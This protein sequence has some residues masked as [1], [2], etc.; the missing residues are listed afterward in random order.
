[1][2]DGYVALD[3][4]TATVKQIII[5]KPDG[6]NLTKGANFVTDGKDGKLYYLTVAGDFDQAGT[7]RTQ[8]KIVMP[9][10]SGYSSATTFEVLAN[11]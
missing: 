10:F 11:I 1:L 5:D 7:Y 3:I 2:R 4:S 6:T 9:G 8:A